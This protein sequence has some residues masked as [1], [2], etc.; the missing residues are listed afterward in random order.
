MRGRVACEGIDEAS[1]VGKVLRL[2]VWSV[3]RGD[4]V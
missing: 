2:R 1:L 4:E 3:L